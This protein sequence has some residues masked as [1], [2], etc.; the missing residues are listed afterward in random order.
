NADDMGTPDDPH[1]AHTTNPVP[2]IYVSPDGD[3]DGRTV[4][5]GGTLADIAPT[6]L[7]LIAIKIPDAMTGEQLVQ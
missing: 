1:T 7:S 2:F 6:L 5:S 4:R 3:D